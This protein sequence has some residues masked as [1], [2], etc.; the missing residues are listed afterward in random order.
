MTTNWKAPAG[1]LILPADAGRDDWLKTR[2]LGLGGSDLAEI[3]GASNFSTPFEIWQEKTSPDDPVEEQKDIFWFGQEVEPLLAARFTADTGIATRNVGTYQSKTH[4]FLLANPDRFTADGGVLEIKTTGG[5]TDKAK[6]WKAG[7]VPDNAYVQGQT[8]LA[9]TGRSHLWFI[10]LIDRT[11]YIVGPVERDETLIAEIQ[12]TAAEF[13][14][15]VEAN[16]PPPVDLAT[17]T[18]DELGLRYPQVLDPESCAEAP[19]PELVDDDLQRLAE[20][21]DT[22]K[23]AKDERTAIETRL[24]AVIGDH[25]YLTLDGHPVAR[26][27]QVAGRRS[28]D[29]TAVLEKIAAER[30]L[31]PTKQNLKTIEDEYTKVGAPTRRLSIIETKE[32]A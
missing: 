26:W 5:Y 24:K 6:D 28:F 3:T 15:H 10:A 12:A 18:S 23:S 11:P 2:R 1:K 32:A 27:Q 31:D 4:P 21:K 9:V 17:V 25:E 22:E 14:A 30:G 13:W 29:K 20:V 8:Y 16:T 7:E 19:L